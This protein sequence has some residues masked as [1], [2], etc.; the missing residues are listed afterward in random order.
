MAK[1][2]LYISVVSIML[3]IPSGKVTEVIT[4]I[5]FDGLDILHS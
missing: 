1:Y 3:R 4:E 2:P 5:M